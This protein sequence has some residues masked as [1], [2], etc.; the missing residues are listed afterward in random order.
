VLFLTRD[1]A[2]HFKDL[3]FIADHLDNLR[4]LPEGD[5]SSPVVGACL[6]AGRHHCMQSS[7]SHPVGMTQPRVRERA[8]ALLS[9]QRAMW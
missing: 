8:L 6:A 1:Q 7:K 5:D 4:L 3:E 9:Q 2:T